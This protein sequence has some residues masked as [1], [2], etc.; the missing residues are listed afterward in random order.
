[1]ILIFSGNVWPRSTFESFL[2]VGDIHVAFAVVQLPFAVVVEISKV[3]DEQTI[4]V[5]D[6]IAVKPDSCILGIGCNGVGAKGP[7]FVAGGVTSHGHVCTCRFSAA[8]QCAG[9][10]RHITH[11]GSGGKMLF[12][13]DMLV[14]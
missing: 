6:T 12:L 13:E 10:C 8:T 3:L 9:F 2:G 7:H 5:V 11:D 14:G 4:E 1:M